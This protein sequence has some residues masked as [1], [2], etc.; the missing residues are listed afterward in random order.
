MTPTRPAV[1]FLVL[2]AFA[3]YGLTAPAPEA[4]P[5][6]PG[7]IESVTLY[8]GQALVTRTIPVEGPAGEVERV[9]G[10]LPEG[11]VPD[12]LFAEAP[13]G[14]V[15]RAVRFRARTV[16][17]EPREE[18]RK[19]DADIETVE[20]QIARNRRMADLEDRRLAYLDK[21]EAFVAPTAQTELSKGV[22][23]AETLKSLVLFSAEQRK[24]S[25]DGALKTAEEARS[26]EKQLALL[27][28]KRSEIASGMNRAVREAVLFLDRPQ[29]G[30]AEVRLSY[31]VEGASWAPTYT[32]RAD[33]EGK[34][35]R[36]EYGALIQQK[37]GEDWNGIALTLSTASPTVSAEVPG[38]APFWVALSSTPPP[39][40]SAV[41]DPADEYRAIQG[42]LQEAQKGQAVTV[43]KTGNRRF[44]WAMNGAANDSQY[45]EFNV[46]DDAL[47]SILAAPPETAAPSVT[48]RLSSPVSLA[49]RSDQQ[50]VRISES[51][52]AG[53]L[54]RVAV[55]V[56]TGSVYR[57]AKITN[58]AEEALLAGPVNAYL[59]GRFVG[60][61]EIPTV[62]RG[63]SFVVGFGADSQIR[64]R[65]ELVEK[66]DTIQGGNRVL[67]F[68]YRLVVENFKDAPVPV[69]LEDRIP[70]SEREADIRVTLGDLPEKLSEDKVYL[71]RERPKGILRFEIEAPAGASGDKAR[72]LEYGYRVEF[73]K[74]LHLAN[75]FAAKQQQFFQQYDKLEEDRAI[76]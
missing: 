69:R 22:L 48:Y 55:P 50:L 68:R 62:G 71:R 63:Q 1:A 56:L 46:R 11:V 23:N 76:E 21:L 45:I 34:A 38:L 35:F 47:R 67:S 7:R 72:L 19:I 13:A 29:A 59:D 26:L 44:F 8:R 5:A 54:H 74:N 52:L 61:G 33:A 32:I 40:G 9:V 42:R 27:Q 16:G 18:V 28:G 25:A 60:K 24:A 20:A 10:D 12:S 58:T 17:E 65:R 43:G 49:S 3:P 75:P 51:S 30:R 14:V 15:V 64:A 2:A 39:D 53:E 36:V 4:P 37:S 57:Q 31:L 73:D 6:A 70:H 66:T 41:Q